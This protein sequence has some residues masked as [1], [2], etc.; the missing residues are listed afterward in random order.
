MDIGKMLTNIIPSLVASTSMLF[1]LLLPDARNI[2]VELL[3][4]LFCCL[5]YGAVVLLFPTERQ[6][7]KNLIHLLKQ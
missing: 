6:I 7:C 5:I 2:G 1:V 4:V 3:Y